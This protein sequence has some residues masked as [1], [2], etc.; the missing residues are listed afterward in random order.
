MS[1]STKPVVIVSFPLVQAVLDGLRQHYDV[2]H[3][4]EKDRWP[5]AVAELGASVQA[6]VTNGTFGW[7]APLM[8]ALPNLKVI[9]ALGAGYENIDVKAA[10]ERGIP[11]CN[12]QGT[13]TSSVAD[14]AVALLLSIARSVVQSSAGLLQGEWAKARVVRPDITGAKL[15]IL[16]LGEIGRSIAKRLSGFDMEV[17]YHNR[18]RRD[19]VPYAYADSVDALAEKV[20]FLVCSMPGGADT[21]HIINQRVLERLGPSGYLVNVG[22]GSTVDQAALAQALHAGTI[23]GAALDV[24]EGEPVLPE[25]LKNAPNLVV[26]PHIAGYSPG[27]YAAYI[28]SLVE[29]VD[30]CLAG[31]PPVSPVPA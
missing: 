20:D 28:R 26:T 4:P 29:N 27:S 17:T 8:D 9:A 7:S 15:G 11:V 5:A 30:A 23:A 21:R 31:K 16:G 22:R 1:S 25:I 13:N 14:H 6:V 10:R 18:R 12:G 3:V 2:R 19:D 24:F